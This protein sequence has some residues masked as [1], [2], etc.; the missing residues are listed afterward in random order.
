M[1]PSRRSG[2]AL[3]GVLWV[4]ALLFVAAGSI[5]GGR[6]SDIQLASVL[7]ASAQAHQ[8][9]EA[10]LQLGLFDALQPDGAP[11]CRADGTMQERRF[12]RAVIR[13]SLTDEAG[14]I[15]LNAASAELLDGLL[16][17]AALP[18]AER[19]RVL[20][21]ILDWRDSDDATR[22]YGAEDAQYRS[23]GKDHGARNGPFATV[24]ELALVLGVSADLFH[25][26]QPALTV[27]SRQPLII[28]ECASR[29]V[30]LS[31][32]GALVEEV[33]AYLRLRAR[34]REA[35]EAPPPAPES[36][37]PYLSRNGIGTLGIH[38]QARLP[39]GTSAH[40]RGIVDLR[41]PGAHAPYSF[42]EWRHDGP[43]LFVATQR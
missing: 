21:A 1:T 20:D 8:A 34:H 19:L 35:G 3:V 24:G 7:I 38:A 42:V 13:Y 2:F 11:G 10:G 14:K 27:H 22:P 25:A 36:L 4:V 6:R 41:R 33:D 17:E 29:Q 16:R 18:S 23:A 15:D 28:A 30:L 40:T 39:N 9:S 37:S 32:P 12:D 26:L 43:E 31:I 5:A